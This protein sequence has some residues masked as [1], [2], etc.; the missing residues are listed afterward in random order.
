MSSAS[1]S[2]EARSTKRDLSLSRSSPSS[3]GRKWSGE[4]KCQ[5][6]VA[7]APQ[8]AVEIIGPAQ[9]HGMGERVRVASQNRQCVERANRRSRRDDT[10]ILRLTV[11]PDRGNE[12]VIH[13]LLKL[14]LNPHAVL[15]RSLFHQQ[16]LARNAVAGKDLHA[17]RF[18]KRSESVYDVEALDL[19]GITA[20]SREQEH[21]CSHLAP[22]HNTHVGADA[23]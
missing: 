16:R 13:E 12:L 19:L 17:T 3:S 8:E 5:S 18:K 2:P 15:R 21:R 4:E 10:D 22:A 23:L 9:T 6:S 11:L 14:I 7:S 20:R 1:P